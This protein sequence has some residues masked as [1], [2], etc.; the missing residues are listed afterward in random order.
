[1]TG[2]FT[3]MENTSTRDIPGS[4]AP[5]PAGPSGRAVR[6]IT[7]RSARTPSFHYPIGD[8]GQP[9]VRLM[10]VLNPPKGVSSCE[11]TYR[12]PTSSRMRE[13][14]VLQA[15]DGCLEFVKHLAALTIT[16][17]LWSQGRISQPCDGVVHLSPPSVVAAKVLEFLTRVVGGS[18]HIVHGG[19][20]YLGAVDRLPAPHAGVY[21]GVPAHD[22]ADVL[23]G[24]STPVG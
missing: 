23:G 2:A 18:T 17:D 15:F 7:L 12:L 10:F 14:V 6:N 5:T 16:M 22:D 4:P 19:G 24:R 1:M 11:A 20:V 13:Q 3:S 21:L 9:N 8:R